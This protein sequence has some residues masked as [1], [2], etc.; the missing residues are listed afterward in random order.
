M[1]YR[2]NANPN[3]IKWA[4][5]NARFEFDDLPK[6][7]N[8]AHLWESGDLKPTWNDLRNLA[9]KYKRPPVFY[10]RSDPP[11]IEKIDFIEFRS[12]SKIDKFSPDLNLEINK[13]KFRRN[14]YL[15]IHEEN[16]MNITDFSKNLIANKIN[17]NQKTIKNIAKTIRNLLN[18]S[19]ETQSQ[20]IENDNGN[21]DYNHS[22]FLYEWKEAISQLGI[23]I[24]ETENVL[25]SEM[26]GLSIYYDKYP[27]IL[28]NGK[29]KPNRR[30][31][32]L[33][34]ELVHLMMGISTICDVD[35]DNK[36]EFLCNQIAFEVLVPLESLNNAKISK[37][38]FVKDHENEEWTSRELGTLSH[39][40]G[41]SKQT[42]II[43]LYKLKKTS[44]TFKDLTINSLKE[45]NLILK[46]KEKERQKKSNGGAMAPVQK[47][48]KYD[49]KP[50]SRFIVSAYENGF[51]GP[52]EFKRYLNL[53]INLIDSLHDEI[54]KL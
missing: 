37:N 22:K 25:E 5:K 39:I 30:I 54:F 24:F 29:N 13:A 26:S 1:T 4:R 11:K 36:K 40:Y 18:I 2:V 32:T 47:V 31:F 20:W 50:F 12:D 28:L 23:L 19:L 16:N 15:N 10:L 51:I 45:Y 43:Q 52:T 49:G 14:I 7:L 34:H 42:M 3:M 41:V 6:S 8:N 21:K 53:H 33:I 9:K 17:N 48:K 35:I 44:K 46:N 27:I 38:K